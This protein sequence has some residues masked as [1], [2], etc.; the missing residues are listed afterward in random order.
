[1]RLGILGWWWWW[2]EWGCVYKGV[3]STKRFT[4]YC[5]SPPDSIKKHHKGVSS[6][7]SKYGKQ[8]DKVTSP[9]LPPSSLRG[10]S[11]AYHLAAP[12]S[13]FA[14]SGGMRASM[15]REFAVVV[16]VSLPPAVSRRC[17]VSPSRCASGPAHE[18]LRR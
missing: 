8:L 16:V 12:P 3:A 13:H 17:R 11:V 5:L 2:Y 4:R 18:L 10:H 1:M 14:G 6:S 7:L 15:C 9:R